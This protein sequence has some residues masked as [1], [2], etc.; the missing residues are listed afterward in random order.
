MYIFT[1]FKSVFLERD[2]HKISFRGNLWSPYSYTENIWRKKIPRYG[3]QIKSAKVADF[4]R[5]GA[6]N[7]QGQ[8]HGANINFFLFFYQYT[9][10]Y[11][12]L[13]HFYICNY[14]RLK[15]VGW[16][17]ILLLHCYVVIF[18]TTFFI[19]SLHVH[20]RT[21]FVNLFAIHKIILLHRS[22]LFPFFIMFLHPLTQFL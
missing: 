7:I 4:R 1:A 3:Q 11:F 18:L 14:F 8:K 20:P 17:L 22:F 21:N 5:T 19:H 9:W 10:W 16:I 12:F 2:V 13:P 15:E 6:S